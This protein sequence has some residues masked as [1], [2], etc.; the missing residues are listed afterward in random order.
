MQQQ[1][2]QVPAQKPVIP[3]TNQQQ[4][5]QTPQNPQNPIVVP[6]A[7]PPV[8]EE[9]KE[10]PKPNEMEQQLAKER[11]EKEKYQKMVEDM[12]KREEETNLASQK[13]KQFNDELDQL[14]KDAA[15]LDELERL[16]K[17]PNKVQE[18]ASKWM[19]KKRKRV[20]EKAENVKKF[21]AENYKK[22]GIAED[23]E[24]M[25]NLDNASSFPLAAS[26]FVTA[27]TVAHTASQ[28]SLSEKEKEY[29]KLKQEKEDYQKKQ[30]VENKRLME[31]KAIA[32]KLAVE[33]AK[34][35]EELEKKMKHDEGVFKHQQQLSN[36]TLPP[37]STP[38]TQTGPDPNPKTQNSNQKKSN[39]QPN[40]IT[41]PDF[42]SVPF[43]IFNPGYNSVSGFK[44]S[45]DP[46][47]KEFYDSLVQGKK[48]N[49]GIPRVPSTSSLTQVYASQKV[50]PFWR[51]VEL[52][53][54]KFN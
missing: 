46:M 3:T 17:D 45:T 21:M 11:E 4:G 22:V 10:E 37:Q 7:Q 41:S 19:S 47:S 43:S 52:P 33:N 32:E 23:Q 31:E 24:F 12:K 8:Q 51:M 29:Q 42:S 5:Q 13:N 40:P 54:E 39:L 1:Q 25:K 28:L 49:S 27:M 53:G 18:I 38:K 26:S 6:T 15:E 36:Q 44:K 20:Q 34:K 30:E 9:K 16:S 48:Q 14:K 50:Q 35:L 2:G